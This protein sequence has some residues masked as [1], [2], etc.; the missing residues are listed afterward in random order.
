[1]NEKGRVSS[2]VC[3]MDISECTV[4]CVRLVD[5][6]STPDTDADDPMFLNFVPEESHVAARG[7]VEIILRWI[8]DV[9]LLQRIKDR[10]VSDVGTST[11]SCAR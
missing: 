10:R 9:L 4:R 11:A 5:W 8:G 6:L 3:V 7:F 2:V 1:M